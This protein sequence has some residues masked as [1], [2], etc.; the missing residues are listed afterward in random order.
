MAGGK[1]LTERAVGQA[2]QLSEEKYC[3]VAATIRPTAEITTEFEI[4][5]TLELQPVDMAQY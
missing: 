1:N 5:E 4:Q 3:S 2:I